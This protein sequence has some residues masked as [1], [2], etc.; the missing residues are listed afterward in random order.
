MGELRH[1]ADNS[2]HSAAAVGRNSLNLLARPRWHA[3][4]F[5]PVVERRLTEQGFKAVQSVMIAMLMP[6]GS[7]GAALLVRRADGQ[8]AI[9]R[10][11][12]RV[13]SAARAAARWPRKGA[14]ADSAAPRLSELEMI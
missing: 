12:A 6:E 13:A 14:A 10:I 9:E 2:C 7:S 1:F 5:I 11:D 8:F 3:D 4:C